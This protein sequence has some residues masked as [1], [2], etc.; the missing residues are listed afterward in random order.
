M[1]RTSSIL[2][3]VLL[4]LTGC[5]SY[6]FGPGFSSTDKNYFAEPPVIVKK[7]EQYVLRWNYGSIGHYYIP[8]Y[9]V[10]EGALWFSL[11]GTSSSFS[12]AGKEV[13]MLIKGQKKIAALRTGGA[14]WWSR[15]GSLVPL[16]V[17]EEPIQ[18]TTAQRALRVDDR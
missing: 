4:S 8:R 14:L 17:K 13:E 11:Q 15:D 5:V 16:I 6:F 18:S 9:E 7:G 3:I 2:F 1:K 12:L 10:R